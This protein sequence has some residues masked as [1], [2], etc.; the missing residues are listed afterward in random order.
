M[1]NNQTIAPSIDLRIADE[2]GNKDFRAE[3]FRAELAVDI[4]TQIK[5]LRKFRKLRQE[6]LADLIG[7][8]QSAICRLEKSDD[9]VW[10]FETLL[11]IAE[12][13]DARLSVTF[14]PYEVVV[15]RYRSEEKSQSKSSAANADTQT[16]QRENA[17]ARNEKSSPERSFPQG[18]SL[19][20]EEHGIGR[21]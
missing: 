17:S 5:S 12:A 10:K 13:L 18:R 14:E 8:K 7:T 4:P 11:G 16:G 20:G 3:F 19:V 9:P 6:D 15:A 1:D 21:N 2:L